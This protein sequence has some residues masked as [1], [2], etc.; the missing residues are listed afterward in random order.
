MPAKAKKPSS[1]RARRKPAPAAPPLPPTSVESFAEQAYLDYSM[2]V[3]RHRALPSLSDGLKPVQR[4]IIYAMHLLGLD[5]KSKPKKSA[6]T[7]GDV[8]GKFHP[9]GD[10]ACYEAM[11]LMAQD[12][13]IRHPLIEGQG[14]WGSVDDPKSFAA[15]RYTEA[16]L[17]K[18]ADTLLSEIGKG[19]VDMHDNFDGS[20][21]EPGFL[22][23]RLPNILLN[24][25]SGIAVGLSTDVPPHNIGEVAQAC[26]LMLRR[27]KVSDA[28]LLNCL[29]GPDFPGAC[30]IIATQDE[31]AGL[32]SSGSGKLRMRAV[33]EID[34]RSIVFTRLP[35]QVSI[36][37]IMAQLGKLRDAKRIPMVKSYR[38]ESDEENPIRLLVQL[39][40]GSSWVPEECARHLLAL[41]DL[42]CNYR[43]QMN[44]LLTDNKPQT[45]SLREMLG[46]WLQWRIEIVRRRIVWRKTGIA[47]ELKRIE[48]LLGIFVDLDRIIGIIRNSDDP[49]L[50]LRD[51][52]GYS[53]Y[54]I[55]IILETKLRQLARLEE[56]QLRERRKK[57]MIEDQALQIYLDSD[58][59]LK[60]LVRQE[61]MALSKDF[62][63]GRRCRIIED[64]ASTTLDVRQLAPVVDLVAQL[65][66]HGWVRSG[67]A[68]E[69][70]AKAEV[71]GLRSGD[72]LVSSVRARSNEQG[73]CFDEMGRVFRLSLADL[74]PMRGSGEP[75]SRHF[76]C[77]PGALWTGMVASSI[78]RVA[79]CSSAG[80][81]FVCPTA[82]LSSL[83]S[84]G[85]PLVK[86][87]ES[88]R[89]LSPQGLTS[90]DEGRDC[91]L[92]L[93]SSE[94]RLLI[95]PIDEIP[96]RSSGI[97]VRLMKLASGKAA[98]GKVPTESI[99]SALLLRGGDKLEL[100]DAEG[101]GKLLAEEQWSRFVRKR[102]GRGL[103]A[104]AWRTLGAVKL[105]PA[106]GS[107]N[108]LEL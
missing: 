28:D 87:P 45:L 53:D 43:A 70:D 99:A 103:V 93:L 96:E 83:S 47:E 18:Y 107:Q 58:K 51:E 108:V 102:G 35:H 8:L 78:P 4:R 73:Y 65:T 64:E 6:R 27:Q 79:L 25:A 31:I 17:T 33:Y 38:D 55:E 62:D 50:A 94:S 90:A 20:V 85:R 88:V 36:S 67:R 76:R 95:I 71:E 100:E 40:P 60:S 37:Q 10:S 24:G 1:K 14:N 26:A 80:Q 68:G 21:Q 46:N 7:V 2:Y 34:K 106:D 56:M 54:V 13:S 30:D 59:N 16:K 69:T 66:R 104:K 84:Q 86:M 91:Y 105:K 15:M 39:A 48:A 97:G 82:K 81:G 3:V 22:P 89:L 44:V 41:T 92:A 52:L 61:I 23:A 11:V 101:R 77:Q 57:L 63:T 12:F 75:V 5:H 72:G 42:E 49:K 9:H 74:P 29:R 19:T 98:A 32:Y